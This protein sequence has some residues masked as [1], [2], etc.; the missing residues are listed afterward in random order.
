[1]GITARRVEVEAHL[2]DGVPSFVVVGRAD[3]AGQEARQRVRSGITS[4]EFRFPGTRLTVNLAPAQERKEGSGF[5]L[6]IALAVLAV[7]RQ[8]PVE[9]VAR[10]AAAAELGLDGR[11][12]PVRGAL[13]EAARRAGVEAL[14]VAAESAV[15]AGLGGGVEIIAARDLR[16]A[17]EILEGRAEPAPVRD[18]P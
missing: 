17:V 13:A 10:V 18:P 8:A 1:M 3:R 16:H 2:V 4:A 6:A 15:E 12:R 7:S 5:D 9:R 14:I 11:L